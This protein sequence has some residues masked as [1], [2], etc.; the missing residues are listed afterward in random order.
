MKSTQK[1][2]HMTITVPVEIKRKMENNSEINWSRVATK[3][4][5]QRLE[6]EQILEQF[7]EPDLSEEEVI[8]RVLRIRH[9]TK[10]T[11]K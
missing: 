2:I 10:P 11:I 4:F 5:Q 9:K 6:S 1:S 7:S 8:Q 3:A